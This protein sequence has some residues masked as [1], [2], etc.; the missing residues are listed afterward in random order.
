ML[1]PIRFERCGII[2]NIR[3][4]LRQNLINALKGK[5]LGLCQSREAKS[6]K[7]YVHDMLIA[8]YLFSHNYSF[9]LSIF[10]SEVPLLVNFCNSAP[11]CSD[12]NDKGSGNRLKL[13]NDYIEHTLE[14]L[15]IDPKRPEGQHIISSYLNSEAP[16]LL[17]ILNC[18][19]SLVVSTQSSVRKGPLYDKETQANLALEA[20]I[21]NATK[22]RTM[23]RKIMQEKQLYDD[24]LK[25]KESKLKQQAYAIKHQLTSLN[26]KLEEA[27]VIYSTICIYMDLL[28]AV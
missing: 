6:A 16:L 12:D 28:T 2:S 26:A 21:M 9:T 5:D 20:N 4:H 10:A 22:I 19:N 14:T 7:Q 11:Q 8:E 3:T 1:C 17:S 18:I 15:G 24:E 13:Q 23:R 25:T 27:Q